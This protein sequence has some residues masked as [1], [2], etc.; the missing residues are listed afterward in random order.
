M[1]WDFASDK[2]PDVIIA[3]VGDYPTKESLAAIDLA[4]NEWPDIRLRFVNINSMTS[5]RHSHGLG[6]SGDFVT[7]QE[8]TNL[9]TSN[10]PVIVNFH[11]YPETIKSALFDYGVDSERFDVRG[12][13]EHGSTTTP[14]DMHVRNKTSRYNL[15]IAIFEKLAR[16]NKIPKEIAQNIITKYQKKII[17]NTEYIK[18]HGVDTPEIDEWQ[19]TR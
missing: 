10:K 19:W 4:K 12:Y 6:H 16:A 15:V 1:I 5:S 2:N 11:G 9:F 18:I 7:D 8:F 13:I 17:D 3:G 14:F